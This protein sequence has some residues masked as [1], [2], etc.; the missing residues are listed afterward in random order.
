M[1]V[2]DCGKEVVLDEGMRVAV[3]DAETQNAK[4]IIFGDVP[5]KYPYIF[6]TRVKLK[7][8]ANKELDSLEVGGDQVHLLPK[9]MKVACVV[10]QTPAE[11][12]SNQE[13]FLTV[14]WESWPW[15]NSRKKLF[16]VVVLIVSLKMFL[17]RVL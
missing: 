5:I 1:N 10:L 3:A 17:R 7:Q 4:V 13:R 12:W 14:Q 8:E 6:S 11:N 16:N 9:G 2:D 15:R